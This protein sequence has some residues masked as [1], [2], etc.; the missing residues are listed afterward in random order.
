MGRLSWL[1]I[2]CLSLFADIE[3]LEGLSTAVPKQKKPPVSNKP[4]TAVQD[5]SRLYAVMIFFKTSHLHRACTESTII[6]KFIFS[7]IMAIASKAQ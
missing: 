7:H 1:A 2:D 4:T 5:L 3:L 6:I